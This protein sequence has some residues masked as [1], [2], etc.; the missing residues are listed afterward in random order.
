MSASQNGWRVL[1]R[2][3]LATI[4]VPGGKLTCHPMWAPIFQDLAQQFHATVEPLVWPGCWGWADRPIKGSTTTS[5]HA[6]GTAIDLNAPAHPQGVPASRTFT[7]AKIAAVSALL[8]RYHGLVVW[9]G[10]WDRPDTDGMHFEGR[11]G[12]TPEQVT[13]LA[14]T[15][16]QHPAPTPPPAPAPA[17][18][19]TGWTG[20]DLRGSGPLLRGEAGANGSRVQALQRQLADRYPAYRHARG[21]LVD[22]G[23][24]GD[25]TAG[26]LAEF[27]HRSGIPEADGANIGPKLALALWKAGVRV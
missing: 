16:A 9:G 21:D 2:D 19:P 7:P 14:A 10:T 3:Q 6:S 5:N 11:A 26:W 8:S 4:D 25:V 27:G 20:P 1:T 18:A 12:S 24:W 23:W 17:P 13:A 22:D 15:L